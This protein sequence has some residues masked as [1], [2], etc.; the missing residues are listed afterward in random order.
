MEGSV[1][2]CLCLAAYALA[3]DWVKIKGLLSK[4]NIVMNVYNTNKLG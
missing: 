4:L 2:S 1:N 3:G